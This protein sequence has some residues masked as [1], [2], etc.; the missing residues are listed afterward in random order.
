LTGTKLFDWPKGV[1]AA[2][3]RTAMAQ[4]DEQENLRLNDLPPRESAGRDTIARY[5]AQFRAAAY[6]CLSILS[7]DTIDRVYCD[8]HDDFVARSQKTGKPV[9]R[10]F[11]VKT[12]DKRNYQW[13]KLE[14]FGLYKRKGHKPE[15]IAESFAGKLLLHTIRFKNSC[16][17]VVFLTN[18][19]FDDEV[20]DVAG[21]LNNQDFTN[22]DIRALVENFNDA[23]VNGTPLPETDIQDRLYKLC[24]FPGVRYLDPHENDFY[25]LA[26]E[27]L[28]TYSEVD[29]Q[30]AECQQ[31]IH[32]LISLVETKSFKYLIADLDEKELDDSVGIGIS[33]LLN[34]L[35]ISKGAY[36][37]LL[38]GGDLHAVKTASIIQ[39]K[40][41]QAG[42]TSTMIEF[43]SGVKVQWDIWLRDK[44]H[45]LPEFDLNFLLDKLSGINKQL[46]TGT[47]SLDQLEQVIE[48][49]WKKVIDKGFGTTLSKELLLGGVFAA[50]VRSES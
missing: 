36:E 1:G 35:S 40:L 33:D 38:K 28:Y 26:R 43:C 3:A 25:A 42:A 17:S 8:Y 47:I 15:K 30:H 50:M 48:E 21:C 20:E 6:E 37:L 45:M 16:G 39:R 18:V 7:G 2:K 23:F 41:S 11:Q 29:L 13:S 27:A 49:L 19:Q 46:T 9:Y 12:K 34:I 31:I 32:S 22:H 24:L 5:Q 44:R 4:D 10:F 14:I